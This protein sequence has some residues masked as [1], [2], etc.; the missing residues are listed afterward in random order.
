MSRSRLAA[1]DPATG[2]ATSWAPSCGADVNAIAAFGTDVHVGG[3]F[4]D[5]GG[6]PRSRIGAVNASTG[7]PTLWEPEATGPVNAILSVSGNLYAGGAFRGMAGVPAG[8][9]A[10]MLG[11]GVLAVPRPAARTGLELAR[12]APNP[13]HGTTRIEFVLPARA[14][15]RAELFDVV[16]R[17]IGL[18]FDGELPAGPHTIDWSPREA[19]M[20]AG[21]YLLRL[22]AGGEQRIRRFVYTP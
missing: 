5:L 12:V 9:I 20:R 7:A 1:L 19:R 17:R 16:G 8:G 14:R 4:T 2:L 22:E 21:L 15:A 6:Q 3:L 13:T 10:A 18:V 11:S